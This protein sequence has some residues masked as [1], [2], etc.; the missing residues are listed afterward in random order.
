MKNFTVIHADEST[1]VYQ[2][3]SRLITPTV[4]AGSLL[5]VAWWDGEPDIW[6]VENL[7]AAFTALKQFY[8][9]EQHDPATFQIFRPV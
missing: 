2:G 1:T 7:G 3:F 8:V 5:V 4:D 6:L 9:D